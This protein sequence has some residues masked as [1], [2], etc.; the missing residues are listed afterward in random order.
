VAIHDA[1]MAWAMFPTTG[2]LAGACYAIY[3][4]A[5]GEWLALGALEPKFWNEFCE[6][7]GRPDLAPFQHA[8][9]EERA[10]VEEEVRR[11]MVGLS[12]DEWLARF[13]DADVCL[14]PV[15]TPQE[16]AADAHVL[17]RDEVFTVRPGTDAPRQ[18]A[19][20]LGA[21]TDAVLEAAGIDAAERARLR[22]AR[23]V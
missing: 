12:R 1:A 22:V 2:E 6:R 11:T 18:P 10:R 20:A 23:V 7:L 5:D 8:E 9:G 16:A 3:E 17:A 21:D 4:T 13:T 15:Y 14:T 19:P